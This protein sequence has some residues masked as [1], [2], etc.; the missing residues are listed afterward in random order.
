MIIAQTAHGPHAALLAASAPLH[1]RY[2]RCW[3]DLLYVAEPVPAPDPKA[4][5]LKLAL[6]LRLMAAHPEHEVLLWLDSDTLI[7]WPWFDLRASLLPGMDFAAVQRHDGLFNTG[8]FFIRNCE[9]AR[10]F[11]ENCGR[12]ETHGLAGLPQDYLERVGGRTGW[13]EQEWINGL[14]PASGLK[15][16]ALDRKFNDYPTASG[17]S[18]HRPVIRGWHGERFVC[19]MRG[20]S[21]YAPKA[22]FMLELKEHGISEVE[23]LK[24]T[25]V[26]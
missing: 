5:W 18:C 19:K 7:A 2:S 21:A 4:H 1:L 17:P 26:G 9:R 14:L 24:T 10:V 12:G 16:Q 15:V 23:A 20:M 3:S 25:P 11:L 13:H 8:V 6:I 22:S